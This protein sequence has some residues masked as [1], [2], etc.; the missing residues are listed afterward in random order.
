[1]AGGARAGTT[2]R[3]TVPVAPVTRTC[4]RASGRSAAR[5]ASSWKAR[6]RAISGARRSRFGLAGI[7]GL[8]VLEVQDADQPPVPELGEVEPDVL[9]QVVVDRQALP[10]GEEGL[11]EGLV[12]ALP[13]GAGGVEAGEHG[14]EGRRGGPGGEDAGVEAAEVGEALVDVRG[15]GELGVVEQAVDGLQDEGVGVEEDHAL[16]G[17]LP[18]PELDEVVERGVEG[19]LLAL[20]EGGAGVLGAA[21]MGGV[22]GVGGGQQV[23]GGEAGAERRERRQGRRGDAAGVEDDDV[24]GGAGADER[25]RTSAMAP[26]R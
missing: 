19:R 2:K 6:Q 21:R 14:G 20:G 12:G 22:E 3:P 11:E 18:E 16:V 9:Q 5:A 23:A 1:M 25:V 13:E 15:G 7:P 10:V 8:L 26:G 17:E 24:G 4:I